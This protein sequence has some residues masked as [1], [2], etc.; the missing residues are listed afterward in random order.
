MTFDELMDFYNIND[1]LC[2]RTVY[3]SLLNEL[4]SNRVTPVIGAGLSCW[5]GYPLWGGLLKDKAKGTKEEKDVYDLL[6][7][8]K[9]E[10]AAQKLSDFYKPNRFLRVLKTE[11]SPAKI[12]ES[13]RPPFQKLLPKLFK[14]PFVTTNYDVCLERLLNAPYTVDPKDEY[15]EASINDHILNHQ[16]F[17]IKLHG[18]VADPTHLIITKES[19]NSAYGSDPD[20]P[21]RDLPLPKTLETVFKA[22]LPLFLGCSLGA[23]RTCDV[24]KSCVGTTGYALVTKPDDN[25]DF[26]EADTRFDKMNLRV[27][28]YPHGQHEAV[29]V[30]INQLAQDMGITKP[31]SSPK[32]MG[33]KEDPYAVSKSFIGRDLV[34]GELADKL[35]KPETTVLLVHGLAGIG[36][37][38]ICKAVY[39]K[40]K[41]THPDFSMPFVDITDSVGLP[42]FWERFAKGLEIETNGLT[43]NEVIEQI[44]S[45]VENGSHTLYLDNFEDILNA[46]NR[47]ERIELT[48]SLYGLTEGHQLKLLISSQLKV[49]FGKCVKIKPL[50]DKAD[51]NDLPWDELMGLSQTKLFV[52]K[53]GREPDDS[54]RDSF[55][56]LL[57]ELSGHPLSIIITALYGRDCDSINELQKIWLKAEEHIPGDK[58]DTHESLRLAIELPWQKIKTNQAAVF[59]WAL[60]AR[61]VMPI[62][63]DTF[64]ELKAAREKT[65]SDIEWADGGRMLRWYGLTDKTSDQKESMLLALKKLFPKLGDE[66]ENELKEASEAWTHVCGEM[67]EKGDDRKRTDYIACHDRALS[68]LPQCFYLAEQF[69]EENNSGQ[70]LCLLKNSGNY[71]MFD[72]IRSVPLLQKLVEK[73]PG[74]FPLRSVFYERLGDLLSLTGDPEKAMN[75]YDEAEKL[76]KAENSNLGL[77]NVLQSRGDLLR[78]TGEPEKAMTAYDEAEKLFKAEHSNLGLANVLQARGDLLSLTGDPEKAMTAYDE[79]EKL[80]R[81]E[82]GDLG[83]AYVLQSRGDL[84]RQTGEPEK[85][86]TAYDEAEKLFKAVHDDLGIANVLQG[87]GDLKQLQEDWGSAEE[88][89]EQALP[90]YEQVKY[91][92]GKCYTLAEMQLCKKHC[93]DEDGR[94]KCLAELE[95]L[96]PKQPPYVQRYVKRRIEL[97]DSLK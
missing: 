67:L 10:E 82:H 79:A 52:E 42:D 90:L 27:I 62:D 24:F 11:F 40:I 17:L 70:L 32:R 48:D 14:G 58:K 56:T 43:E 78:R 54:E 23:D 7:N 87:K 41:E 18:T 64:T 96:L 84:L 50:D 29:E 47:E 6:D 71:Y 73:I 44:N 76:I 94:K 81:A 57:C 61:S 31:P 35:M 77:A 46:L 21:D 53:L 4:K 83:L 38:E 36:K 8:N 30:L 34:V 20:K 72:V 80:Y 89:Y 39:Q 9:F 33:V 69:L 19:Y 12:D 63:P 88:M 74:D 59:R 55:R 60:H 85:A 65:F 49:S 95:A 13:K 51:V 16:H 86:M 3:N 28:W 75:A 25:D 45:K 22:S 93:G 92:T 37:T 68:F 2:N 1:D 91:S 97:A 66:A 26:D 15:N 5:A